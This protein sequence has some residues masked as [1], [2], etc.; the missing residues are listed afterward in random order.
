VR[1]SWNAVRL[2][3]LAAAATATGYLWRAALEPSQGPTIIRVAPPASRSEVVIEPAHRPKS[4]LRSAPKERPPQAVR[5]RAGRTSELASRVLSP[6]PPAYSP[7][8]TRTAPAPKPKPQPAPHP[9]GGPAPKPAPAPAPTPPAPA[10]SSSPPSAAPQ[11]A[12][13]PETSHEDPP[14][15]T[16]PGWG[17]GDKNHDHSGPHNGNH[18]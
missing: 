3:S 5:R 7:P 8:P 9:S 17:H 18:D 11:P 16:K 10:P 6:A 1:V 15:G 13:P 14:D 12:P 4:T 2:A